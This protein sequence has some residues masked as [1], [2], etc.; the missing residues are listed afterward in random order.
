MYGPLF[1]GVKMIQSCSGGPS[2]PDMASYL[3]VDSKVRRDSH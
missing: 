1:Q 2:G 3:A